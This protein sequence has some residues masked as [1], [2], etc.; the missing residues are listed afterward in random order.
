MAVLAVVATGPASASIRSTSPWSGARP[1]SR[2][3]GSTKWPAV[4]APRPPGP[5]GRLGPGGR[6]AAPGGLE[7]LA[8]RAVAAAGA[9]GTDVV[10]RLIC[11]KGREES[12]GRARA[13]RRRSRSAPTSR[14][15][16]SP[17]GAA[18]SGWCCSP[19][20]PTRWSGRRRSWLL[21]GAKTISYAVNMAAQRA[22]RA[23]G[24]DDAVLVGLGGEL[25][26]APT[27]SV[28]WRS[29]H[30]LHTPALDPG[31]L[32]GITRA[33]RRPRPRP[34][35][36]GGGGRLHRRGPGRRRRGLP[37]QLDPRGHARGRGRRRPGGRR[38]PRPGRRRP[39][40]RPPPPGRH[41]TRLEELTRRAP[42]SPPMWSHNPALR[43]DRLHR[44]P[45]RR[46]RHHDRPGDRQLTALL[47]VLAMATA[48][49][50]W[51]PAA[52]RGGHVGPGGQPG[53]A[54]GGHRHHRPAPLVADH[55]AIYALVEGSSSGSCRCGSRPAFGDRHP[56]GGPHLR[57]PRGHAGPLHDPGD[58]GHP[59]VPLRRHRRHL[60]IAVYSV[61][62]LS[63]LS[64]SR[65]RSSTTPALGILI[66]LAIVAGRP[67][68]D[69]RLST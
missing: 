26:E 48:S 20:R 56:G 22:A 34:R 54:R 28:W 10:L 41:R 9:G 24:A 66:S 67:Q 13:G 33:V 15:R 45:R 43:D 17:S 21:P 68:P 8:G 42:T 64:G 3:C 12:S 27:A 44:H 25:L 47:L 57:G 49:A 58:Q 32:A 60:Y 62:F 5:P 11:T 63:A 18:G 16:S 30:T 31:I 53:R 36:Q 37:L 55:R 2:P 52:G 19:P 46:G 61:V 1:C 65:C 7:E 35:P 23:R 6:A 51:V 59:A 4:P 39:P 29:G 14:R 40:G 38:P 69:A 50:S